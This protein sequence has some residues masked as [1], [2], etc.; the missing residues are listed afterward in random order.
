M[1]AILSASDRSRKTVCSSLSL[2]T[3]CSG[4]SISSKKGLAAINFPS[5][6]YIYCIIHCLRERLEQNVHCV[7][8]VSTSLNISQPINNLFAI[9]IY[10]FLCLFFTFPFC[11]FS[12]PVSCLLFLLYLFFLSLSFVSFF[13]FFF[14]KRDFTM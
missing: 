9:S 7:E 5:T 12:F 4:M 1:N 6:F 13:A 10:F 3:S 11:T 2:Q 8:L 14:F